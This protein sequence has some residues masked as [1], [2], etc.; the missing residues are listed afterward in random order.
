MIRRWLYSSTILR[1]VRMSWCD[2]PAVDV[3]PDGRCAVLLAAAVACLLGAPCVARAGPFTLPSGLTPGEQY[4]LMFVTSGETTGTSTSISTYNTYVTN[5][6]ALNSAL[7]STTWTAVASTATTTAVSNI[8]CSSGCLSDPIFLVDGTEVATSTTN[9]FNGT[10]LVNAIDLT[11]N[12]GT[13]GTTNGYVWTGSNTSGTRGSY[14]SGAGG[15]LGPLGSAYA[16][17]GSWNSKTNWL[18]SSGEGNASTDSFALYA[19]SGQLTVPAARVPEPL[20]ASLLAF[21]GVATW[22]ARRF[23]R[24]HPRTN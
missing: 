10:A 24:K 23:R 22:L 16:E 11:Q 15:P 3:G 12:G 2:T 17:L 8:S 18:D 7:P 19:I 4:R 9:L 6:A 14:L 20:S 5:Q 21:G 1:S 13:P